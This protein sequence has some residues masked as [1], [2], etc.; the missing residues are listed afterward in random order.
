MCDRTLHR[1]HVS[2][3][4]RQKLDDNRLAGSVCVRLL[5]GFIKLTGN[6][7]QGVVIDAAA[8]AQAHDNRTDRESLG[9]SHVSVLRGGVA[10]ATIAGRGR[11]YSPA[12]EGPPP[13][14]P[15][16]QSGGERRQLLAPW[17]PS[18]SISSFA[19]NPCQ[20]RSI[21]R[22]GLA[23]RSAPTFAVPAQ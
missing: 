14:L 1:S 2:N 23:P 15:S 5:T 18:S 11:A 8:F 4:L 22:A 9:I 13:F 3:V 19:G 17:L 21:A 10:V 20:R 16:R 7:A 6:D 12:P